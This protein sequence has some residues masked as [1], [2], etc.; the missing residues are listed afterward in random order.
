MS[1]ENPSQ[2]DRQEPLDFG[3]ASAVQ[4]SMTKVLHLFPDTNLLVQC[5]PLEQLDWS[6]WRDFDEVHLIISRPVQ[7]EIDDH[8]NKGGERLARR[9]RRASSLLRDIIVGGHEHLLVR[10][11]D[12]A[13]KLFIRTALRPSPD[14]GEVLDYSRPCRMHGE[15]QL[16]A[17]AVHRRGSGDSPLVARGSFTVLGKAT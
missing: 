13:V 1:N 2:P 9:A 16:Q 14:L 11:A 10:P 17:R 12:P 7:S 15:R 5:H 3:K 6:A 4:E 8:K